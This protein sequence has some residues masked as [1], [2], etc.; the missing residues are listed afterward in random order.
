MK[1]TRILFKGWGENQFG[2]PDGLWLANEQV[3]EL[4]RRMYDPELCD[5]PIKL[6]GR[7]VAPKNFLGEDKE[8]GQRELK[9]LMESSATFGSRDIEGLAEAG[10]LA[11]V[12]R[13]SVG[14]GFNGFVNKLVASGKY[15]LE[16][17]DSSE[18]LEINED[19]RKRLDDL[20]RKMLG[21]DEE[22]EDDED[23]EDEGKVLV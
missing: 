13:A 15:Q 6:G 9:D 2:R 1:L 19:G 4:V 12:K 17:G 7:W 11:E 14:T 5:K 20:K 3:E 23:E 8:A 18:E 10:Y 22:E 21:D 16:S